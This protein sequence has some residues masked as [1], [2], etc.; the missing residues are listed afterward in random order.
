MSFN[1]FHPYNTMKW[2]EIT[3][4][5]G[6]V[7]LCLIILIYRVHNPGVLGY[8]YTGKGENDSPGNL[9]IRDQVMAMEWV[10]DNI[11]YFGGDPNKVGLMCIVRGPEYDVISPKHNN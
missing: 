11:Q 3:S 6:H 10:R 4:I 8:L 9:G 5:L 7:W 1:G 2:Y